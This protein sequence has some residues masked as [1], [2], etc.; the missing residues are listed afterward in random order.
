[1]TARLDK[2]IEMLLEL[3]ELVPYLAHGSEEE[4]AALAAL[5]DEVRTDQER[6]PAP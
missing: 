6:F 4:R 1:M 2:A 3:G 5:A